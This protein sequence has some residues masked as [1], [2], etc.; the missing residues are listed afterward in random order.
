MARKINFD[1]P[2][3]ASPTPE[4]DPAPAVSLRSR[5][6]LGLERPIKQSS[7]LGAISQ[8]LGGI[9]EKVRRAEAIEQKLVEGQM[10]VDLDPALIDASFIP[11]RM[12]ATEEQNLAFRE[13]IRQYGQ[14]VPILVRPRPNAV[15]ITICID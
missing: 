9:N 15:H 7:A 5:P 12:A 6:L 11:D 4:Q 3:Q 13:M 10:I 14:T 1:A 2:P 8:S